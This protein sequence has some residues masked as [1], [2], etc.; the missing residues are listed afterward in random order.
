MS[1]APGGVIDQAQRLVASARLLPADQAAQVLEQVVTMAQAAQAQ[2]LV[3]AERSGE[4]RDS[5]CPTVRTFA[6]TVLR[7]GAHDASRLARLSRHLGDFPAL[8]Q[9]YTAGLAHTA[10]LHMI[11]EHVGVCGL[12]VLQAH[13]PQLVLLATQAGPVRSSSSVSCWPT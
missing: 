9:A 12:D 1:T 13:E 4:L 8:A 6:A 2:V 3:E 11:L 5:G 10:N 7:R